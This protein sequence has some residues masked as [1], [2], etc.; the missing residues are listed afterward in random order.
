MRK[1]YTTLRNYTK[2]Y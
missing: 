2:E 1:N